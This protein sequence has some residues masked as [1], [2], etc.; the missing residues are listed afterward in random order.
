MSKILEANIADLYV[1]GQ[2]FN[3]LNDYIKGK[4]DRSILGIVKPM[5]NLVYGTISMSDGLE[6]VSPLLNCSLDEIEK[7]ITGAWFPAFIPLND[8]EIEK[9]SLQDVLKDLFSSSYFPKEWSY[10]VLELIDWIREYSWLISERN[11][12]YL[13]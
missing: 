8:F 7:R 12:D 6:H 9:E 5:A 2:L 10:T 4:I 13:F 1:K 3:P 11:K